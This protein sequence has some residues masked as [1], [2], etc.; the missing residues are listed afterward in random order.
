MVAR[1]TLCVPCRSKRGKRLSAHLKVHPITC[2][3]G[4][5]GAQRY[6][7][8]LSPQPLYHGSDPV[9]TVKEAGWDIGPAWT[10]AEHLA[11]NGIRS[12][13][14]PA[15]SEPLYR[16]VIPAPHSYSRVKSE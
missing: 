11:P 14:R 4:P 9:P 16:L 2:H 8:T 7:S 3:E 6:S 13:E 12:P 1:T 5:K 10:G 15:R